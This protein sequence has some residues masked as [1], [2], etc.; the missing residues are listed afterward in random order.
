MQRFA[1]FFLQVNCMTCTTPKSCREND[2]SLRKLMGLD[3]LH[4]LYVFTQVTTHS[5]S[6]KMEGI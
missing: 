1:S 3:V 6:N 5:T 2:A 4:D